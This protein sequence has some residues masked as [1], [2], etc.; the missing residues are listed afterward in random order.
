MFDAQAYYKSITPP[1]FI[2]PTGK[3]HVGR[4][5]GADTWFKLQTSLRNPT[6]ADGTTDHRKLDAAMKKIAD[7]FFPHPWWKFREKS[8]RYWL[9]QMP[10][11]GRMRAIWD[12]MQSQ[13]SA[14]GTSLPPLPGTSPTSTPQPGVDRPEPLMSGSSPDSTDTSPASTTSTA[15]AG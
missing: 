14:M 1:E 2:D 15:V 9:W 8:V 12:F 13:A 3:K 10:F 7:A 6:R 5:L 11:M 4:I